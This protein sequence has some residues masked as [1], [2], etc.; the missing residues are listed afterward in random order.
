MTYFA[1]LDY[2]YADFCRAIGVLGF[3]TYVFNYFALSFRILSSEHI[4]FFALNISAATM[5]L[6]S[7]TQDFNLASVLIQ[8]FWIVIGSLAIVIRLRQRRGG[9]SGR[10]GSRRI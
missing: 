2:E 7:L 8:S 5:V 1:W 4:R 9:V 3:L 10:L 6:I